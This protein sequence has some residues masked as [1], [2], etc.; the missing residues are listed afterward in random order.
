ML[1]ILQGQVKKFF[2]S[3]IS[4]LI[5]KNSHTLFITGWWNNKTVKDAALKMSSVLW[6]NGFCKTKELRKIAVAVLELP[7]TSAATERTF[8]TNSWI[9]SSK[10]NR[11]TIKRSNIISYIANNSRLLDKNINESHKLNDCNQEDEDDDSEYSDCDEEE[12]DDNNANNTNI[13]DYGTD[14]ENID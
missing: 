7:P 1:S 2:L 14:T 9:H 10:R 13:T 12:D 11:L 8:S 6:W 4:F 3:N 5:L